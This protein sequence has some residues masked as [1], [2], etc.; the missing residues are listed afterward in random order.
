MRQ[1]P[2]QPKIKRYKNQRT[3]THS[4]PPRVDTSQVGGSYVAE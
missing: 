1:N 3:P 4:H 2:A